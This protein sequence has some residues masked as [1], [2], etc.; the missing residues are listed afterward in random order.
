MFKI[1][2]IILCVLVAAL[3]IYSL[4]YKK[5]YFVNATISSSPVTFYTLVSSPIKDS[6]GNVQYDE[7]GHPKYI[8]TS[9]AIP[10]TNTDSYNIIGK[11][12]YSQLDKF[13]SI[14]NKNTSAGHPFREADSKSITFRMDMFFDYARGKNYPDTPKKIM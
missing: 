1:I 9:T 14:I 10:E 6:S 12:T 11:Y 5:E 2:L 7:N 8:I 13:L 3:I 4:I